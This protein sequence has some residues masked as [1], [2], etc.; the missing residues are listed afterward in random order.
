MN[1]YGIK[2]VTDKELKFNYDKYYKEIAL[3]LKTLKTEKDKSEIKRVSRE[4]LNSLLE[5]IEVN[6]NVL[7]R[8]F[9]KLISDENSSKYLWIL[10][11]KYAGEENYLDKIS[12]IF[13]RENKVVRGGTNT[14]KANGWMTHTLYVYQ[15]ANDNIAYNTEIVNFNGNKEN[16]K[17]VQELHEIY[18][19]LSKESKFLLKIFALIHDIGVVEEVKDH[20]KLGVKYV[21]EVLQ[22]IGLNQTTLSEN[23][24]LIDIKDFTRILKELIKNHTLITG[25]SS[26]SSDIY[27]EKEYKKLL[28]EI[29]E[30]STIKKDIS[31]VLMLLAYGDVIAVD[32]SLMDV[33]KYQR[34]KECYY[35]FE[36]ISQGKK[37]ERDKERV[38]IERICD[39]I[40]EDNFQNFKSKFNEILSDQKINKEQFVENMYNIKLMR[41]TSPLMKT[42][43][44]SELSM[45]IYYELFELIGELEG[46]EEL[47]KYTIVFIPDRHEKYF[48]EEFKNDNFFKCIEKMKKE[49]GNECTYGNIKILKGIDSEGKYLHIRVV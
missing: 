30:I 1:S 23:N 43:N 13:K 47:K 46:K 16:K 3:K 34:T 40:G 18:N 49:K 10:Y 7:K 4:K 44:D 45:K 14:Y 36:Q 41:F 48:V 28:N 26:E 8:N 20:D 9:I 25:L 6:E 11:S 38:A 29:P 17:Q 39:M 21:E 42:L 37:V 32:E 27:I 19:K 24:I 15:I 12:D 31:K 35:F 22:E 33:E 2:N 5:V